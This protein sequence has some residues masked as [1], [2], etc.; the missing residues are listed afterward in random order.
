M[1]GKTFD[2]NGHHLTGEQYGSGID[3]RYTRVQLRI[4]GTPTLVLTPNVGAFEPERFTPV[5]D[6]AIT[7]NTVGA[8]KPDVKLRGYETGTVFDRRFTV[9]TSDLDFAAAVLTDEVRELLAEPWFRVH[10][11]VWH[12]GALWTTE[13]GRLTDEKVFRNAR[14]LARLAAAMPGELMDGF[15]SDVDT[16]EAGWSGGRGLRHV[17]NRR[18]VARDRQPLSALSLTVRTVIALA[19]L[20]PGLLLAGNALSAITGLAPETP[21]TVTESIPSTPSD[22]NCPT[23]GNTDLVSGTY[24]GQVVTDMWWMTFDPLPEAGDVVPVS[25]GPLWWHPVVESTDTAV[26]LLLIALL[27]LLAGGLLAK[28]TYVPRRRRAG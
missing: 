14:Q 26:F 11:V 2:H 28:M 12:D 8:R 24:D 4:P 10:E 23:C 21:F 19:L 20:V 13:A 22:G 7:R 25:V 9:S 3:G 16:S 6:A 15:G 1:R 27:P 17:L 18:R 5:E